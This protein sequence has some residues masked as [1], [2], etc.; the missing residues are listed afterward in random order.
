VKKGFN[1]RAGVR[2]EE[3]AGK[4]LNLAESLGLFTAEER[5]RVQLVP[6]DLTDTASLIPAIG[7]ATKVH[8]SPGSPVHLHRGGSGQCSSADRGC[9]AA[10]A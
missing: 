8:T 4:W 2:R 10:G 3:E 5:S 9:G 7:N 6:F 1:V